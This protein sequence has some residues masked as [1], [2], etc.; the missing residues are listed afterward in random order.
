MA[1]TDRGAAA[2]PFR[3]LRL[4]E[5]ARN[6]T[7]RGDSAGEQP[8]HVRYLLQ[9]PDDPSLLVPAEQAWQ[10]GAAAA[11]LLP[12]AASASASTCSRRSARPPRSARGSRRACTAPHPRATTSTPRGAH[13][14]LTQTA[15][16]LLEQAGFGVLLPAWWTRRRHQASA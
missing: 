7:D 8:W 1:A 6:R 5:P 4:E 10:R 9:A 2:A 14:F 12:A 3:L 15:R 16:R 11:R 13:D